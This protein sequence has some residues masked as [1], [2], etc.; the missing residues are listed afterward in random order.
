M[1]INLNAWDTNDKSITIKGEFCIYVQINAYYF[2]L[3]KSKNIDI[4]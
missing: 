3:T 2:E 4:L 1:V